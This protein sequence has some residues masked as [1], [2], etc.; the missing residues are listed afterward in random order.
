MGAAG[1]SLITACGKYLEE[2]NGPVLT[3]AFSTRVENVYSTYAMT[4]ATLLML[5]VNYWHY[6][7]ARYSETEIQANVAEVQRYLAAEHALLKPP[8]ST[9]DTVDLR[10]GLI[11]ENRSFP[12]AH[13]YATSLNSQGYNLSGW[14]QTP[15]CAD[16]IALIHGFSGTVA[17]TMHVFDEKVR[18]H[19]GYD[20]VIDLKT[21]AGGN[22]GL[23]YTQLAALKGMAAKSGDV[24]RYSYG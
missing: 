16:I 18:C 5:R 21:K 8:V 3:A 22:T 23:S 2:Q 9:L 1:P 10:T 15:T 4:A 12:T 20:G 13:I 6:Y 24:K 17:T 7:P 19:N 14:N 11:W